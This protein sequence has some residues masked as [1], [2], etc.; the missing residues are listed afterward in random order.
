MRLAVQICLDSSVINLMILF[1]YYEA[2]L[3]NRVDFMNHTTH[4][5]EDGEPAPQGGIELVFVARG[6]IR[7]FH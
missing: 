4:G 1:T 2:R 5:L 6:N 7:T 3:G